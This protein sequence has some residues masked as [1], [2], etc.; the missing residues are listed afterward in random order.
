MEP[1]HPAIGQKVCVVVDRPMG[2]FHPR[3]PTL[4]YPI[5]YGYIPGVIGGDGHAQDAYLLGLDAVVETFEGVVI[6]VIRR[7]DDVEDKWVVAP[8]GMLFTREGIA[9]ATD[10]VERFFQVEIVV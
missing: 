1:K 7:L 10:F 3:V 4:Y 9:Q 8:E 5:N 2:S 6:A